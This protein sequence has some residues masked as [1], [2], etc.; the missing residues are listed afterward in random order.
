MA[1]VVIVPPYAVYFYT[2]TLYTCNGT[3]QKKDTFFIIHWSQG[4]N[5]EQNHLWNEDTSDT[6]KDTQAITLERSAVAHHFDSMM[7]RVLS[8]HNDHV[9]KILQ[10]F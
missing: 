1:S 2:V 10:L 3:F 4:T 7:E 8:K 5:Y 9:M 6:D